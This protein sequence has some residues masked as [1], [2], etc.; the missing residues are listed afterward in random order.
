[1]AL[2]STGNLY[3]SDFFN[4]RIRK[5]AP[6]G[7]I[8]TV[9]GNG[10]N[11]YPQFSG[12]GDGPAT[13]T[14]VSPWGI[15]LDTPGRLYFAD[16]RCGIIRKV[17]PGGTI[18][19]ISTAAKHERGSGVAVDRR[20]NL[21][22]SDQNKVVRIV[23]GGMASTVAGTGIAGYS[24]DGGPA[25]SA[26]LNGPWGI[27]LDSK[28][29]IYIADSL[30]YRI[31]KVDRNGI[32]STV[33][34]K[35]FVA[36]PP[37]D[38]VGPATVAQLSQPIGVAVDSVGNLF[39]TEV[40]GVVRRV[41]RDGT[42]STVAGRRTSAPARGPVKGIIPMKLPFGYSGDGGPATEAEFNSPGGIAVGPDGKIYVADY[43]N[44]CIRVLT[45]ATR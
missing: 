38:E 22:V 17:M 27:A 44:N 21:F 4:G 25:T 16:N 19:T 31:R 23:P 32:I 3:I 11:L 29:D 37:L 2:D 8:T 5:V 28:G 36:G 33:A 13:G 40:S 1:V 7:A 10:A 6:D 41:V 42:I 26:Q 18:S 15:A 14:P 24:G 20:G 34:G 30:N 45:P 9:A 35:G 43:T 12:C 39:F